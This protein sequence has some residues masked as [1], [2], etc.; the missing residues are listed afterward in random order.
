MIF[1]DTSFLIAYLNKLDDNH[2]KACKIIKGIKSYGTAVISD[3]ILDELAT[4]LS[5]HVSK[6]FA[7]K[8]I[9]RLVQ[10]YMRKK[11]DIKIV[12]KKVFA[13]A[14]LYFEKLKDREKLSFTDASTIAILDYFKIPYLASFDGDF[15]GL[16]TFII[17]KQSIINVTKIV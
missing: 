8:V 7:I 10:L 9:T 14:Y 15:D 2:E 5:Y 11:L 3:Y 1:L 16:S 13:L 17:N 4:F 6:E 12:D